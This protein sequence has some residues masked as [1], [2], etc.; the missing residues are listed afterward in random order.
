VAE[1]FTGEVTFQNDSIVSMLSRIEA[2]CGPFPRHM[3]AQGRQSSSFFT[4][5]GL[6][7][8]KVSSGQDGERKEGSSDG[9]DSD[10]S[11]AEGKPGHCDIF[12]PKATTL[13][14]RLGYAPC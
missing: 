9:G 1:M 11:D 4:K 7:Y 6:L 2:L 8:E 12:Q 3:I 14:A 13:S 5:C 10:G